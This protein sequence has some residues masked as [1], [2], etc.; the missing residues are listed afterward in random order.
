MM[1]TEYQKDFL[2]KNRS[3]KRVKSSIIFNAILVGSI[4]G[5]YFHEFR[6]APDWVGT[7]SVMGFVPYIVLEW[8][9][10]AAF[11]VLRFVMYVQDAMMDNVAPKDDDGEV[12]DVDGALNKLRDKMNRNEF[13]KI[14]KHSHAL[15][16]NLL[17]RRS[18]YG[19]PGF[20]LRKIYDW[21]LDLIILGL[22]IAAD[23]PVLAV[24]HILGEALQMTFYFAM[25]KRIIK[26]VKT[27]KSSLGDE[28]EENLDV[29]DLVD[30]L[31]NGEEE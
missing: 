3:K 12:T 24:F 20:V 31:V 14:Q 27:K 26:Y 23:W 30:R 29:D 7:L 2:K 4:V 15:F 10:A 9:G 21:S 1:Y 16:D 6:E 25:Q 5:F 11:C 8:I 13:Q 22:L 18:F 17:E 19:Q 28:N